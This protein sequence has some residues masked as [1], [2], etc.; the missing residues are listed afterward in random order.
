MMRVSS[1]FSLP[2]LKNPKRC[3][4]MIEQNQ[5]ATDRLTREPIARFILLKR[6]RAA[7]DHFPPR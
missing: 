7:A 5:G 2:R 6:A 1:G 4:I 3:R